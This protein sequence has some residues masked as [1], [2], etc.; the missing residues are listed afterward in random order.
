VTAIG[1]VAAQARTGEPSTRFNLE[2]AKAILHRALTAEKTG[3]V[4]RY[5]NA[6]SI[7]DTFEIRELVRHRKNS[8]AIFAG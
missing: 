7:A 3:L 8:L 2:V 1:T 6:H 4:L 5:R